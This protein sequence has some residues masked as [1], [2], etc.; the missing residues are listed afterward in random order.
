MILIGYLLAVC[1]ATIV[2]EI[3]PIL[4]L[5]DRKSW[6]KASIVCNIVTN[7]LLNVTVLL[8]SVCLPDAVPLLPIILLSE[9]AV[10]LTEAYFYHRMLNA[11]R[12]TCLMF[13]AAANTLSFGIGMLLTV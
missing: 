2:L 13:S 6:W 11:A 4:F 12:L 10:V 9:A 8:L 7:P 3:I 5:K 1:L